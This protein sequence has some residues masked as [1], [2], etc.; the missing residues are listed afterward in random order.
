[1]EI[2]KAVYFGV[3]Q[4]AKRNKKGI[5]QLQSDYFTKIIELS[6]QPVP[7][8]VGAHLMLL[9]MRSLP[10]ERLTIAVAAALGRTAQPA[11]TL[12]SAQLELR[13]FV[14]NTT[15][16]PFIQAQLK[17]EPQNPQ[18]LLAQATLHERKSR[19]YKTFY[20]RGF[21]IARR[22]QD[23][24]ALQAFR[25]EDWLAN[26]EMTLRAI[27]PQLDRLGDPRDL[28]PLDMMDIMKRMAREAFGADVPP[29][30]LA[31]MIPQLF[32]E[33]NQMGGGFDDDDYFDEINLF[34]PPPRR[35]V[36]KAS[37]RPKFGFLP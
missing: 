19:E 2:I 5:A 29:E 32:N 14:S 22:L 10:P 17:K 25:E 6:S 23:A 37:K 1:V 27:G 16:R 26:Q 13:R 4:H 24:A 31:Q 15:L 28:D 21:E 8:A 35:K 33:I 11:S 3:Q 36:K 18:L 34:S 20:D 30:I 12:A 9:A 7:G